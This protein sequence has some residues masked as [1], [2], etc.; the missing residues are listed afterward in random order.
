MG[1]AES[2]T[3]KDGSRLSISSS[4]QTKSTSNSQNSTASTSQTGT[5][6]NT[7]T[8][9]LSYSEASVVSLNKPANPPAKKKRGRPLGSK[10]K[11]PTTISPSL[12]TR[13]QLSRQAATA[14]AAASRPSI[15]KVK[16][17][18]KKRNPP[19][20]SQKGPLTAATSSSNASNASPKKRGRPPLDKDQSPSKSAASASKRQKKSIK[21]QQIIRK[22][23]KAELAHLEIN[24]Y[25]IDRDDGQ[26]F[27][28]LPDGEEPKHLPHPGHGKKYQWGFDYA[29]LPYNYKSDDRDAGKQLWLKAKQEN[30]IGYQQESHPLGE[31]EDEDAEGESDDL[32]AALVLTAMDTEHNP[33]GPS[34]LFNRHDGSPA[35]SRASVDNDRPHIARGTTNDQSA[36]E[37][38]ANLD[39]IEDISRPQPVADRNE[40]SATTPRLQDGPAQTGQVSTMPEDESRHDTRWHHRIKKV[41]VWETRVGLLPPRRGLPR[42]MV[43]SATGCEAIEASIEL[44]RPCKR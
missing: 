14:S 11:P 17:P 15:V 29:N 6:S 23:T 20:K 19:A 13:T 4:S 2:K 34:P 21:D 35:A 27:W 25:R 40:E 8:R 22:P 9:A 1:Q 12:G 43:V 31:D 33:E 42:E 5:E 41:D 7:R 16:A 30:C 37:D 44:A 28:L 39:P 24:S 3:E 38:H 26:L 32:D 10:N 18:R 36:A